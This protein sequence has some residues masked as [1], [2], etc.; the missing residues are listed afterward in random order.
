MAVSN[1]KYRKAS[2][3]L[4]RMMSN[5]LPIILG[6]VGISFGGTIL[7]G[8]VGVALGVCVMALMQATEARVA[9]DLEWS[10]IELA[11][12]NYGRCYRPGICK[13][14]FNCIGENKFFFEKRK[15]VHFTEDKRFIVWYRTKEWAGLL[16]EKDEVF[17]TEL[18]GKTPVSNAELE[19]SK[20]FLIPQQENQDEVLKVCLVLISHLI[21]KSGG[22]VA[23]VEAI[24]DIGSIWVDISDQAKAPVPFV[25]F[26]FKGKKNG[27][28]VLTLTDRK[29]YWILRKD[30]ELEPFADF[31]AWYNTP[32]KKES[33]VI[34]REH[35]C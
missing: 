2:S 21:D 4:Y 29:G 12:H 33:D 6:L 28:P 19:K 3:S 13:I 5:V 23:D 7:A 25:K 24:E 9:S 11:V 1:M 30:G 26:N 35:S 14:K 32:S 17:F 18:C 8:L 22:T 15:I 16:D 34:G 20:T 27:R 10:D 31:D